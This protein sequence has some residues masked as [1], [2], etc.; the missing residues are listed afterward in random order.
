ML[1]LVGMVFLTFLAATALLGPWLVTHDPILTTPGVLLPPS[2]ENWLGTDQFGRDVF[3]RTI[4]SLRVDFIVA[5]VGVSGAVVVGSGIG[6]I[7]G[8]RGGWIDDL[9]MRLVDIVQSFPLLLLAMVLILALG[10]G[11]E[12]IV[13]VTVL[14][15]IPTYARVIRGEALSKKTLEYI[16]AARCSGA[17]EISILFRHLMPNTLNPIVVHGSLNLAAAVGNV[18]ALSF[19]GI[20]I[21]PP[22][23]DLGV[24]VAEGTNYLVQGAW[25]MSIGPGIVL[26]T[27]IFSLNLLGDCLEARLDPRRSEG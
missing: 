15:N 4:T 8:Y 10:P 1:G 20:G 23:P 13:I 22:T 7:C 25:W 18:A 24:M 6:L 17:S 9:A 2:H 3:S 26:A 5:I 11:L 19:L 12:S 16:D 14:I 21:R 27:T